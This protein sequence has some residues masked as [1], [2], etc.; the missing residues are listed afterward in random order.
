MHIIVQAGGRGSRLRH[1]TWN[2]PKCLVSVQ[3]KP[4]LYHLFDK[5]PDASYLIIGN[6]AF[7]FLKNYLKINPPNVKFK[8]IKA[9]EKGTCAGISKCAELVSDDVLLVWG[10]LLLKSTIENDD[11]NV[12]YTTDN[13]ICRYKA[14]PEIE[15]ETTNK[16]GIP[17]IFYFDKSTILKNV[18]KSGEFV[19]WY[20]SNI[21]NYKIKKINDI[22]EMG[23]FHNLEIKNKNQSFC[24]H[25]NNV[26]LL[27]STVIKEVKD[28]NYQHLIDKEIQ[29]YKLANQFQLSNIPVILHT[30]PLTMSKINGK[31]IFELENISTSIKQNILESYIDELSK[32]HKSEVKPVNLEEIK[33]VY[34]TKT[35]N[36]VKKIKDII[37][38]FD[39]KEIT[40]NGIKCKNIFVSNDWSIIDNLY[41]IDSFNFIHGDP[42][43]SNSIIAENNEIFFIDPRGYFSENTYGDANY[44]FAKL[45]YS[46]VGGYDL[47]NRKKF[48]LYLDEETVELI[49]EKTGF[50]EIADLVFE[51]KLGKKRLAQI[52]TIHG[53]LWLSLSG[54]ALDDIDSILGAFYYGLYWLTLQQK[55][56]PQICQA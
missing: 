17:G 29:W 8:L 1:H 30:S 24:R 14:T 41:D 31:H 47:F 15:E 23:D 16:D 6:Y 42:T 46:A 39:K 38:N 36:R 45:Y 22:E 44:D 50:E 40:I 26:K 25:F 21:K 52:K 5:F 10:D 43:F 27:E 33:D 4:I 37:P 9:V 13:I 11:G 19:Q 28:I 51:N 18:P 2:K 12:L 35:L 49:Q 7:T 32:L 55:C 53:L 54:Y 56:R 20:K 48:K 34:L 3:G